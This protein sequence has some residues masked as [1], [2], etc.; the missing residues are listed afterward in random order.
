MLIDRKLSDALKEHAAQIP[1][2]IQDYYDYQ[3]RFKQY[4]Q[5]DRDIEA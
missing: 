1:K 2:P 5:I 4:L 3:V